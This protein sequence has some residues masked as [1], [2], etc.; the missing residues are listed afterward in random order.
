MISCRRFLLTLILVSPVLLIAC[1][2]RPATY[3]VTGAVTYRGKPVE[4]AGVMFMP[5][6]G[7]PASALTDA[8]GRFTLRTFKQNDGAMAGENVVCISKM[9]P[10][11]GDK[12]KE[13]MFKKMIS[14]LPARYAT[15]TTSP[16]K[17][18]ISTAGPNEFQFD[19]T[20]Q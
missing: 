3:A 10:Q 18:T 2:Q 9:M 11:P 19:L 7:R 5:S 20:D 1:S 8:E 15:P 14:L 6:N 16:L 13:A 17:A 12:T 4:G